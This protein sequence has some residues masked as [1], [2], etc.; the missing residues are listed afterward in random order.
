M[1]AYYQKTVQCS[2]ETN[3]GSDP[4]S[5]TYLLCDLEQVLPDF[6]SCKTCLTVES[7]KGLMDGVCVRMCGTQP[8]AWHWGSAQPVLTLALPANSLPPLFQVSIFAVSPFCQYPGKLQKKVHFLSTLA[9][10]W[11]LETCGLSLFCFWAF[12][13]TQGHICCVS[14]RDNFGVPYL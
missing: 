1:A 13:R 3:S 7:P 9:T 10:F 11:N 5:F 12:H 6:L 14:F 8:R 4:S 2:Q